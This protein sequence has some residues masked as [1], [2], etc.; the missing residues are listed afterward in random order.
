VTQRT[1]ADVLVVLGAA[2]TPDGRLGPALAE[3]VEAGVSAWKSGLAPRL[4]M[5]GA[6]E[7]SAMRQRAIELGVPAEAILLEHTALTTRENALFSGEILRQNGLRRALL[8]TQPYHR[9]RAVAAFRRTGISAE[10]LKFRSQ[11]DTLKQHG[12][13]VVARLVYR[14]RGWI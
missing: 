10:A 12:R 5:T 6:Y 8:V 2:L 14:L 4:L 7:A 3:R 9:R 11:R 13:E 1:G